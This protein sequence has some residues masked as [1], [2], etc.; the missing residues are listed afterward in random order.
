MQQRRG[1]VNPILR[2][3]TT[4]GDPSL[5]LRDYVWRVDEEVHE[6]GALGTGGTFFEE[7]GSGNREQARAVREGFAKRMATHSPQRASS[8]VTPFAM[9]LHGWGIRR[10]PTGLPQT[11]FVFLSF[12]RF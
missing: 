7:F 4:A 8:P 11:L 2:G 5:V 9:R 12:P 6:A 3:G 1:F 10:A